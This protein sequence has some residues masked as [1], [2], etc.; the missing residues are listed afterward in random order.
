MSQV[1][2]EAQPATATTDRRCLPLT[3]CGADDTETQVATPTS[4]RVCTSGPIVAATTDKGSSL[5]SWVIP[6]VIAGAVML[7]FLIIL[8]VLARQ[9]K[10]RTIEISGGK[11]RRRQP[12][13][14]A[15]ERGLRG[16]DEEAGVKLYA[17]ASP[18]ARDAHV[19]A[20]EPMLMESSMLEPPRHQLSSIHFS[21]T[22]LG[23][24]DPAAY[25]R[26]GETLKK[27]SSA[28]MCLGRL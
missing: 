15:T 11:Q 13:D 12:T 3:Q 23:G 14:D 16:G 9:R 24:L 18:A 6:A 28:V 21:A 25:Q 20:D 17:V 7:V 8:A 22:E 2:Y 27:A 5:A 10:R 1:Q 19:Y 26:G 4:D